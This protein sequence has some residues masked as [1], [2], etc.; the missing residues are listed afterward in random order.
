MT[1]KYYNNEISFKNMAHEYA[2]IMFTKV[3]SETLWLDEDDMDQL[4]KDAFE[5][6]NKMHVQWTK[7]IYN[8]RSDNE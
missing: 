7:E 1:Y 8:E 4:V 3:V 5:L 2:K 6:A